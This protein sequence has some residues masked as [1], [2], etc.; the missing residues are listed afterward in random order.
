M[1]SMDLG[2]SLAILGVVLTV[3]FWM[4]PFD[5]V[6]A[7]WQQLRQRRQG[8]L[9]VSS[10]LLEELLQATHEAPE[11]ARQ[12]FY[13]PIAAPSDPIVRQLSAALDAAATRQ[14]QAA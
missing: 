1:W 10:E 9:E 2:I 5:A 3:L 12:L 14:A 13:S 6:R 11:L 4:L 8:E 7:R